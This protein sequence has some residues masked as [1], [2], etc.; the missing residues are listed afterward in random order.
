MFPPFLFSERTS[1]PVFGPCEHPPTRIRYNRKSL[2][3]MGWGLGRGRGTFLQKGSPSPL[4]TSPFP[5]QRLLQTGRMTAAAAQWAETRL[6][7]PGGVFRGVS[8]F[9]MPNAASPFS[10]A[11]TGSFRCRQGARETERFR[12]SVSRIETVPFLGRCAG[13]RG[14]AR[15]PDRGSRGAV[16]PLPPEAEFRTI[17]RDFSPKKDFA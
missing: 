6:K 17:G 13:V 3:R 16:A 5:L 8:V 1:C 11:E 2:K 4:R 9:F 12:T 15:P 14:A 10:C 7:F